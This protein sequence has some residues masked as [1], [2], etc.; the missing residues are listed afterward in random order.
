M[1]KDAASSSTCSQQCYLSPAEEKKAAETP[2]AAVFRVGFVPD[3]ETEQPS[4]I[5]REDED[6][7]VVQ[8]EVEVK[9]DEVSGAD[10]PPG[11]PIGG[12]SDAELSLVVREI[13]AA[14]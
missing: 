1:G 2:G 7:A 6:V 8:V 5:F 9:A 3:N 12:Y 13:V 10:V 4:T 14:A 11:K